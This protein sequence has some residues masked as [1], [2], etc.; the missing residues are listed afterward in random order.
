VPEIGGI[1]FE[2]DSHGGAQAQWT[3]EGVAVTEFLDD[4]RG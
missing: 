1:H 4:V 2:S 3:V